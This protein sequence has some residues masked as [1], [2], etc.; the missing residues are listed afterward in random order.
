[1]SRDCKIVGPKGK[2]G[3][4]SC[5]IHDVCENHLDVGDLV[6]F[7]VTMSLVGEEEEVVI[8]VVKIWYGNET[9]RVGFLPPHIWI[10]EP[11]R[12]AKEQVFTSA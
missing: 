3:G 11:K 5:E 2:E 4:R 6:K 7:K 9:Y 12:Q 1:M 10:W 8:K